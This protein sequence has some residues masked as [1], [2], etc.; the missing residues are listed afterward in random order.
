MAPESLA[1]LGALALVA[2]LQLMLLLRRPS[3]DPLLTQRLSDLQ[4]VLDRQGERVAALPAE[5]ERS[6]AREAAG[7]ASPTLEP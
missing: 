2:V 3:T 5:F 1:M 6:L 7:D 4:A